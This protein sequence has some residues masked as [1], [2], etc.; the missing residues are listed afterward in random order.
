MEEEE[1]EEEGVIFW[2]RRESGPRKGRE[3]LDVGKPIYKE[4][5]EERGRR[6][7]LFNSTSSI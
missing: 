4:K 5:N 6:K 3:G 2:S 7:E 1:E